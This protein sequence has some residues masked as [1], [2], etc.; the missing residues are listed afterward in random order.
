MKVVQTLI[1]LGNTFL[2]SK[3]CVLEEDPKP[4]AG[5]IEMFWGVTP[6]EGWLLCHGG[7]FNKD[8]YPE[9]YTAL[10]TTTLPDM[11]TYAPVGVG[12]RPGV[13][14][15][16]VYNLG[17]KRPA[18][19]AGHRHSVTANIGTLPYINHNTQVTGGSGITYHS[20]YR[21]TN[22][23]LSSNAGPGYYTH[24]KRIGINF[25]IKAVNK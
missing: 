1:K 21:N 3:L 23:H 16:D 20:N 5:M 25:I 15:H 24:G 22:R 12:Q 14:N 19:L 2:R 11:R 18:T 9:L 13:T 4:A 17:T 10:G 6:P 8:Q 7:T